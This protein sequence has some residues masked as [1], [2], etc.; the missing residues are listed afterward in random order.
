MSATI[1][2]IAKKL[3]VSRV[4]ISNVLHNK[5]GVGE[6]L[7]QKVMNLVKELGYVP[8]E[9]A[10]N[11]RESKNESS[12]T[13]LTKNIGCIT[14]RGYDK[15]NSPLYAGIM[16]NI[17]EEIR[18][19]GYHLSFYYKSDELSENP[20]LFNKIVNP[21]SIDGLITF[22]TQLEG[23]YEQ[24]RGRIK[25]II[26]ISEP[27]GNKNDVDCI[28]FDKY[29]AGHDATDYLLR[30]NHKK[31]A[32]VGMSKGY[33]EQSKVKGYKDALI[34]AG[35]EYDEGLVFSSIGVDSGKQQIIQ[36]AYDAASRM[37]DLNSLPTAI[38]AGS[39]LIC[40][41]IIEV[42][43]EKGLKVSDDISL[44]SCSY[45]PEV[46][47]YLRLGI[48]SF[49]LNIKEVGHLAVERLIKRIHNPELSPV[50]TLISY[51]FEKGGT[52]NEIK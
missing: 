11:L 22:S 50:K 42:L 41:G 17:D 32:F 8:N 48:T 1:K 14:Y 27:L 2:D 3:N 7:R 51:Q 28:L 31:I 44:I 38:V 9:A 20:L 12:V 43:K 40:I 45:E 46:E 15:F 35:I 23:I 21:E 36:D 26:S 34:S 24:V 5:P 29:Q 10:L 6:K 47:T 37:M 30:L 19:N 18:K 33:N 49:K 25:N 13:R 16:E 52:C 4:T 39:H